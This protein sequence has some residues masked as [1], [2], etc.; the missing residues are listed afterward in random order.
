MCAFSSVGEYK[1][2][3]PKESQKV[4]QKVRKLI[5]KAVPFAKEAMSYGVPAFKLKEKNL[6]LYAVFKEHLGIYPTPAAI[7]K[8]SKELKE[9]KTSKGTIKF[10]LNKPIPYEL[11][12]KITKWC[13]KEMRIE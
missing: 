8:F 3:L 12:T 7:K 1:E 11:I 13:A 9:Y 10:F 2:S 4:F 6:I 5:H